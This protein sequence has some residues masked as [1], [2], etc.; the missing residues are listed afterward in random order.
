MA[1][2]LSELIK[3]G[4][5]QAGLDRKRLVR[6]LGYRN[7]NKG[8]GRLDA[9]LAGNDLP[10][11]RDQIERLAVALNVETS[12]IATAIQTDIEAMK[13][14]ANA[15]RRR[16]P[17]YRVTFRAVPGFYVTHE[18]PGDLTLDEALRQ[19]KNFFNGNVRFAVN[20]PDNTTY[21]CNREGEVESVTEGREPLM[22]VGGKPL[23]VVIGR[24]LDNVEGLAGNSLEKSE[25][26]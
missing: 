19:A 8:L 12:L 20:T 6:V 4:M 17:N 5:A 15:E 13:S 9:W 11:G 24:D 16:N 23:R 22:I 26:E 2:H 14:L 21:W 3:N 10:D 25:K 18:L 7:Q 1:S